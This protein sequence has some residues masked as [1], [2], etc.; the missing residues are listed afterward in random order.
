MT[1]RPIN[2]TALVDWRA[3]MH[4]C[5]LARTSDLAAQ[6]RHTFDRTARVLGRFLSRQ[7]PESRFRVSFRLYYGWTKGYQRQP[8]RGAIVEVVAATDFSTLSRLPN[9]VIMPNVAY[10]DTLLTALP[11]RLQ[12][13]H[14]IH[15]PGTLR[16][17]DRAGRNEEKM[18][19]TALASDL[20]SL[21]R[22]EPAD[23]AVVMAEDDDLVPAIFT[24]E[25]WMAPSSGRL[26]LLQSRD[27]NNRLVNLAG[28]FAKGNW[29]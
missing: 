10:G 20:L 25:A 22:T 23:W 29:A 21:A 6:A 1:E 14:G 11:T 9:V 4:N 5:H 24:A 18:V 7:S 27:P 13:A 16:E 2:V 12:A 19:D 8:S 3:Q 15:L 17:R 26:F 28:I